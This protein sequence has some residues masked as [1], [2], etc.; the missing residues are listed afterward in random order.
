MVKGRL[1][2]QVIGRVD[3]TPSLEAVRIAIDILNG[4]STAATKTTDKTLS[5]I[6]NDL[7]RSPRGLRFKESYRKH[8]ETTLHRDLSE[9]KSYP[10]DQISKHEILR[11]YRKGANKPTG[12]DNAFRV[13]NTF[14]EYAIKLEVLESNPCNLVKKTG[15]YKKNTR[16]EHLSSEDGDVG[17]FAWALVNYEPP[18]SKI[19]FKT[20][21]DAIVLM[22]V[23]G[24]RSTEAR[25]LRWKDIDLHHKR[26]VIK[27][28]KNRRDRVLPMTRLIYALFASRNSN[29]LALNTELRGD[30]ALEYVF[31]NR[32]GTGPLVDIRKT[33]N[34]IRLEAGLNH[35]RNHDL[36]RTFCTICQDAGIE[37]SIYQKLVNHR[38]SV[39]SDYVQ[40]SQ[41]TLLK[42]LE[43][44]CRHISLAMPVTVDGMFHKS[45]A[46]THDNFMHLLY[47]SVEDVFFERIPNMER[48]YYDGVPV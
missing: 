12:T 44:A 9:F 41:Q 29:R 37:E 40:T 24:L 48:D 43:I 27:D 2:N 38:T 1:F 22:F 42:N 14:F 20:A 39:T 25:T 26:F 5:W 7:L 3:T 36:R 32:F 28:T 17:A 11:W 10:I 6:L 45:G 23:T 34:A 30:A 19:N 13:L 33:L 21:R 47:G 16:R 15:R 31:P 35:V 46:G 8:L 18:Q 4:K